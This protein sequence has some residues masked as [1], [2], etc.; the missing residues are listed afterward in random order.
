[1]VS[2]FQQLADA[3]FGNLWKT[4]EAFYVLTNNGHHLIFSFVVG[5]KL[6]GINERKISN[7]ESLES[8]S[9]LMTDFE[10]SQVLVRVKSHIQT[11][12]TIP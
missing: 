5:D 6:I 10:G 4:E 7:E 11:I 9:C 8:L 12:L 1:M 3:D 2:L